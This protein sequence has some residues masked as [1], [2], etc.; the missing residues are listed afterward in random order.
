MRDG[1]RGGQLGDVGV[2]VGQP[3]QNRPPGRIGEGAEDGVEAFGFHSITLS[4]Y[5]YIVIN[6]SRVDVNHS[7]RQLVSQAV[8]ST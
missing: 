8:S 5:N 6:L 7:A 3:R 2:A 1:E 4:F